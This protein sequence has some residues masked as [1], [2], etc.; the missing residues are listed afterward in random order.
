MENEKKTYWAILVKKNKRYLFFCFKVLFWQYARVC[1]ET[2]TA[3][4]RSS[5]R[6]MLLA[7]WLAASPVAAKPSPSERM[8]WLRP[9]V[10]MWQAKGSR[11][12]TLLLCLLRCLLQSARKSCHRT[13]G[14]LGAR[15]AVPVCVS[16]AARNTLSFTSRAA[17]GWAL[18]CARRFTGIFSAS[19]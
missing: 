9:G 7:V 11:A 5:M 13:E 12:L 15:Q 18:L 16:R 17:Q 14:R 6:C 2:A 8:A 4:G 1:V 19:L 3:H 10:G